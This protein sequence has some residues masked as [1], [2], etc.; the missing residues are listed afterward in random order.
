MRNSVW[1][2]FQSGFL[3]MVVA[4]L[5]G[6]QTSGKPPLTLSDARSTALKNHPKI[7]SAAALA[8]AAEAIITETRSA[9]L[10]LLSGN[11]TSAEAQHSTVLAAGA[12]QTSSLYSRV[13][14]GVA[15]SQLITDFG[16]TSS[17]VD[18]ASLRASAQVSNAE[19]VRQV[20]LLQVEQSFCQALAAR[21][22][23]QA[24]QAAVRSREVLLRQ[25]RAL[26]E[27][28]MRSTLD[29]R[30]AEVA[31]SQAQLDLYRAEN[32]AREADANLSAA[33]GLDHTEQFD[34]SDDPLPEPMAGDSSELV[35][36]ALSRRPD[37]KVFNLQRDAARR[38]AEAEGRLNR[39][40][41]GFIGAAGLVPGGDPRL[42][43]RY[44]AAGLNISIPLFNGN[45]FA[46]RHE[47]ANERATAAQYDTQDAANQ[48]ARQV[49]VAWLEASTAARR[50]DVS[51]RLV[52]E[53]GEALRLARTRYENGLGS[54]VELSQ[55]QL[56]QTAAE[57]ENAS[58]RYDYLS[59]RVMLR[60]AMGEL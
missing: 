44:S 40:T 50:I 27:S 25:V 52:V 3:G 33:M 28:S 23:E 35:S 15:V 7:R 4:A 37:L 43:P 14:S 60:Y 38:F 21:A 17:L 58:S 34:L 42:P 45:L 19:A 57:I 24:A 39:P 13:A 59:R 53:A 47:E 20:V 29:V 2:A 16:R 54:I 56:N 9:Q 10:P 51:E 12:L 11:F 18:S 26:A 5:L 32:N 30:F 48:I 36:E 6:G 55:A 49:R 46:S 1:S 41:V 22:V 31:L 8:R